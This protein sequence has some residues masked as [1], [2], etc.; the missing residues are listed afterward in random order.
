MSALYTAATGMM[1]QATNVDVISNNIANVNTTGYKT[2]RAEF[3]DLLYQQHVRPG[4]RTGNTDTLAPT[5]VQVGAGVKA[6]GVSYSSMQGSLKQTDN[7]LDVALRSPG[8]YLV[9]AIPGQDRLTYTRDG[10]LKLSADGRLVTRDGYDV[11][12]DGGPVEIP[13]SATDITINEAGEIFVTEGGAVEA[14]RLGQLDLAL[15]PN[16]NGLLHVGGNLLMESEASGAPVDG[17]ANDMA[18]GFG[19]ISQGYLEM[20]N[21]NIVAEISDLIT[22]QRGYEMNGKVMEAAD[23][24]GQAA[25]RVMG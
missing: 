11:M 1:A 15:F 13:A 6:A 23:Q 10:S 18:N 21:V 8:N 20:S 2:A 3:Q 9:V 12:V 7:K 25:N 22:A 14:R 16:E 24:M 17:K 4:S 19:A 5:G